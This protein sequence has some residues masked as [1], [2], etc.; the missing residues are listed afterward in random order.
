MIDAIDLRLHPRM[1]PGLKWPNLLK[2]R[3][4]R[5]SI[6]VNILRAEE[7]PLIDICGSYAGIV[8]SFTSSLKICEQNSD[9][10]I[11]CVL[12]VSGKRKLYK[13]EAWM[14]GPNSGINIIDCG[15]KLS[16]SIFERKNNVSESVKIDHL[17]PKTI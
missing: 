1:D 4:E 14:L 12:N 10:F 11:V 13:E 7:V 8:S 2:S 17:I 16:N 6:K 9:K 15:D 3:L 5:S